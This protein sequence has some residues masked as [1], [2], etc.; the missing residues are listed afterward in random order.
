MCFW[1]SQTKA[2]HTQHDRNLICGMFLFVFKR[3]SNT[4]THK[5]FSSPFFFFFKKKQTSHLS[6]SHISLTVQLISV[7]N[8]TV[9]FISQLLLKSRNRLSGS[10]RY[11]VSS[12]ALHFIQAHAASFSNLPLS[13]VHKLRVPCIDTETLRDQ[14]LW[15]VTERVKKQSFKTGSCCQLLTSNLKLSKY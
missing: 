10:T 15:L 7:R 9:H 11:Q 14:D 1:H 2:H 12:C 4:H 3:D 13:K 5:R 8:H 6:F